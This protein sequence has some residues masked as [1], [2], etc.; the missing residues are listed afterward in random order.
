MSHFSLS[1]H[2]TLSSFRV[3]GFAER[4]LP[5]SD[6]V[7]QMLLDKKRQELRSSEGTKRR[8]TATCSPFGDRQLN[9]KVDVAVPRGFRMGLVGRRD[10]VEAAK[11]ADPR[12]N[13]RSNGKADSKIVFFP[14]D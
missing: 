6:T 11:T 3:E 7:V 8:D 4:T 10:A 1:D 9:G 2:G 14:S 5:G 12:W 13:S